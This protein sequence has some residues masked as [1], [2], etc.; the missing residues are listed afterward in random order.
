MTRLLFI[1]ACPQIVSSNL[2][3]RCRQN[4]YIAGM[5]GFKGFQEC[6]MLKWC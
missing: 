1:L 2:F 3:S 6:R 5:A 4:A